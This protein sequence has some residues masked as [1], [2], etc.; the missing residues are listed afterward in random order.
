MIITCTLVIIRQWP[1][2]GLAVRGWALSTNVEQDQQGETPHSLLHRLYVSAADDY[3]GSNYTNGLLV[4][5]ELDSARRF[6]PPVRAHM[7]WIPAHCG[8]ERNEAA[9]A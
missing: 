4:C 2:S 8:T 3:S 9:D 7:Q 1:L 6:N 5:G